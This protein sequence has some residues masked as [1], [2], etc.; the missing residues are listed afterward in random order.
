MLLAKTPTD[1]GL[2]TELVGLVD[3]SSPKAIEYRQRLLPQSPDD[4]NLKLE[5]AAQIEF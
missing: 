1:A 2:L 5:L 4:N 3:K